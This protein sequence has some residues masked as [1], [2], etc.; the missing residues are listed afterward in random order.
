MKTT[1]EAREDMNDISQG[2]LFERPKVIYNPQTKK[3]VMWSH[4]ES[5]DGYGACTCLC[6][7]KR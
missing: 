1:G 7:N 4:W 3:W 5:G 2:R 6:S